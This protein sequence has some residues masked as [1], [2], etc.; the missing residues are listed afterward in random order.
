MVD[1]PPPVASAMNSEQSVQGL[2]GTIVSDEEVTLTLRAKLDQAI[3]DETIATQIIDGFQDV[4]K[5][6]NLQMH[7]GFPLESVFNSFTLP[8]G[9]VVDI[10]ASQ[11]YFSRLADQLEHRLQ[12]YK[13]AVDVR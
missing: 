1:V 6:T 9:R 11:R 12:T 7:A 2:F 3:I 4:N 8:V 13:T 10:L 5:A